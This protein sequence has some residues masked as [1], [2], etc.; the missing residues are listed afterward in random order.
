MLLTSFRSPKNRGIFPFKQI[1]IEVVLLGFLGVFYLML[2]LLF[3]KKIRNISRFLVPFIP[4]EE[5]PFYMEV[6]GRVTGVC[7]QHLTAASINAG[8]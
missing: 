7:E 5:N 1:D 2:Q 8:I 4:S 3:T 6:L